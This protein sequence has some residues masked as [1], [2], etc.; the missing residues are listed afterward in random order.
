MRP[1]LF[2][3]NIGSGGASEIARGLNTR[4][5]RANGTFVPGGQDCII[6]WGNSGRPS[7]LARGIGTL[8]N[9]FAAV[10]VAT[11]KLRT[12][13]VFRRDN[14]PHPQWTTNR[15]E[16]EGWFTAEG[17]KVVCRTM[18]RSS[19]GRGIVVATRAS[20]LVPAPLYVKFFGKQE[21][22]RVHVFRGE[23]IDVAQKRLSAGGRNIPNRSQYIRSHA[24]GWIFAH[25]NVRLPGP[26][27][28]AALA[29][30]RSVGLDFGA[31]DLA[32]NSRGDVSVFEVN[33]A[34]GLENH[35][36]I[37]AYVNAIRRYCNVAVTTPNRVLPIL[38]RRSRAVSTGRRRNV[39]SL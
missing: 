21:E 25:E 31:V 17:S 26:A 13:E 14:V 6:N 23:V 18:L 35:Q 16:A 37:N 7:W 30:V 38:R 5:V 1:I 19:E 2:P 39:Q 15:R 22:Y 24:N 28:D 12:F 32:V 29:A 20:E 33:T 3:Y 8:L 9:S 11:D 36:T 10:A 34:P 4:K 27:R